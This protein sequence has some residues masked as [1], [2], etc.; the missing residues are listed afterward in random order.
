MRIALFGPPGVGKGTQAGLIIKRKN[1]AQIST[2]NLIRA[3]IA[4]GTEAGVAA[5]SYVLAGHLVPDEIVR[6]LAEDAIASQG[7]DEFVLDGY[8]RTVRQAEWLTKFLE[9]HGKPLEAVVS[10]IV[11]DEQIVDRLSRRRVH[12]IT[13]EVYH[14]DFQ[15]PPGDLDP[16]LL[17]QRDDD[18]PEAIRERLRVYKDQTDP[19][20]DYYSRLDLLHRIDGVGD[21]E[22]VYARVESVLVLACVGGVS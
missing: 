2:G 7:F 16:S 15:P 21:I 8:P 11:S 1:L 12:K 20:E 9:R 6:V 22:D 10:L 3:A 17:V 13:G 5:E 18:H 14:M 4:E 19:V